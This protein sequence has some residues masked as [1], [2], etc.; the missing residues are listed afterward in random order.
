MAKRKNLT[1]IKR[2]RVELDP[3]TKPY[4]ERAGNRPTVIDGRP[5]RTPLNVA[6]KMT[7]TPEGSQAHGGTF[8]TPF[9]LT[10]RVADEEDV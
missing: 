7:G 9:N 5:P 10:P 1:V 3:P 2:A 8:T 6:P 4:F